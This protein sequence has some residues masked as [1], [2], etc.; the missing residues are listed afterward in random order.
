MLI[1][2]ASSLC[3]IAGAL[4]AACSIR[5][6]ATGDIGIGA[7]GLLLSVCTLLAGLAGFHRQADPIPPQ[8]AVGGGSST[9]PTS[10]DCAGPQSEGGN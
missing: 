1:I 10:A 6:L 9:A 7:G 4:G 5:I 8:K 3:L 2:S